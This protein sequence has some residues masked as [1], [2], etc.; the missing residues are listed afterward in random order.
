MKEAVSGR[1]DEAGTR[2]GASDAATS[3]AGALLC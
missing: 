2:G 3:D 1:Q